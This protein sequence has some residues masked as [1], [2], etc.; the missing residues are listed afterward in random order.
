MPALAHAGTPKHVN[1]HLPSIATC[2]GV[3]VSGPNH[4]HLERFSVS[5]T[6]DAYVT[7]NATAASLK[8]LTLT[9]ANVSVPT[10]CLVTD[11]KS[12]AQ[13]LASVS[14]LINKPD[15]EHQ[16]FSTEIPAS[17]SALPRPNAQATRG[18]IVTLVSA[19]ALRDQAAPEHNNSIQ[20][21]ASVSVL[22]GLPSVHRDR[23]SMNKTAAACVLQSYNALETKASIQVLV[24]VNALQQDRGVLQHKSST[25][26]PVIVSVRTDQHSALVGRSSILLGVHVGVPRPT[27]ALE[28]K[29]LMP[30]P[31]SVAADSHHKVARGDKCSTGFH[32]NAS[33][34]EERGSVQEN[35][36]LI[37]PNVNAAAHAPSVALEP[38]ALIH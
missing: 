19:S 9:P 17:V 36:Y 3:L 4:A 2:A 35:R 12:L 7:Q 29:F 33:V 37:R 6:V 28:I 8:S 20:S 38:N 21:P 13:L 10:L 23:F 18:S 22:K 14:V 30:Q 24:S 27:H 15:A 31:V 1:H 11:H 25:Q 16:R 5:E 32:V 26:S 34:P